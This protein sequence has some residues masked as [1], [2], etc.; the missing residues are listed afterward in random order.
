MNT[1][2]DFDDEAYANAPGGMFYSLPEIDEPAPAMQV[3]N[4]YFPV[5]IEVVGSL[6]TT[7]MVR[8]AEYV[9]DE[10]TDALQ[11]RDV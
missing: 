6:S 11:S 4:Y 10:L 9:Y 7:E 3:I 2:R 1:S 5:E 8:L